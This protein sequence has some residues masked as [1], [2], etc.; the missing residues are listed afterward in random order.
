MPA[1]HGPAARQTPVRLSERKRAQWHLWDLRWTVPA[2]RLRGSCTLA[3]AQPPRKFCTP[4]F[5]FWS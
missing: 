1:P 4:W 2:V 5:W 3:V